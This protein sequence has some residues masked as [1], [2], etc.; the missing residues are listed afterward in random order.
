MTINMIDLARQQAA[1]GDALQ[2]AMARVLAH[3][4]FINGPEVGELEAALALRLGQDWQA[5]GCANGTDALHLMLRA[6]GI[7]PGDGVALPALTFV[8]TAEAVR[9]AGAIPVFVDT[10]PES[11]TL[12]PDSLAR[13][14][15]AATEGALPTLR[16]VLPVDLFSLPADH[17]R[18]GALAQAQGLVHLVDA[19][20]SYGGMAA[21]GPCGTQGL[22]ASTSFYP[23]KALGCFGDGGAVFTR[24]ADL[25]TRIR[26]VANHG[27][28]PGSGEHGLIG[29]NSRLDTLQAAVLLTKLAHFDTEIAA[30]RRIADRYRAE[31]ADCCALPPVAPDAHPV[32]SYFAIRHPASDAL[33]AHLE[34][35]GIRSVAYYRRPIHRQPAYADEPC[36]PGG[37][38]G[39]EAFARTLLCLPMHPYLHDHEVD[40]VIAAV[41]A[42]DR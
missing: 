41:R 36:V 7:G 11:G 9:L 2:A 31:L 38:P 15:A 29:T 22:A 24:D 3:K 23:S 19:A 39:T 32:W 21:G 37:L 6:A 20:H 18:I 28:L 26:A 25:A 17:M 12:C 16:A 40:A 27:M 1:L 14:L 42:F 34:A 13:A 5:I 4:G 8:A 35:R 10:D 30:R 33:A